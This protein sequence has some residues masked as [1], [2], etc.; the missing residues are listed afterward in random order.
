MKSDRVA[1]GQSPDPRLAQEFARVQATTPPESGVRRP[2]L[3][4]PAP[5]AQV[6]AFGLSA[7]AMQPAIVR[8]LKDAAPRGMDARAIAYGQSFQFMAMGLAP[9]VAGIVGPVFGLRTYFAVTIVLMTTG[10]VLWLK[11]GHAK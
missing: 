11:S 7:A 6:V 1:V 4:T 8:L 5:R 2:K 3:E 9:F 10:L